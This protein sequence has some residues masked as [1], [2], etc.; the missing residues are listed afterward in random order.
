M[1]AISVDAPKQSLAVV[2]KQHLAFS[3]LS[4]E[5]GKV[6]R[7]YGILHKGGGP[8]GTDIAVPAMFLID[9]DGKLVWTHK[10]K[11]ITDRP[12]PRDVLKAIQ[13]M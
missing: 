1:L 5:D 11:R 7:E 13:A 10:A 12:N 2:R 3:I 8:N 6:I 4:D 9:R